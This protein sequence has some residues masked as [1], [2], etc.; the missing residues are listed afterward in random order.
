MP[1]RSARPRVGAH[2]MTRTLVVLLI[3]ALMAPAVARARAGR[4]DRHFG[5]AGTQ[6]LNAKNSD[7]VGGAVLALSNGRVLA[8]GAAAGKFVVL[9]LHSQSGRLDN[10]FGDHGQFVPDLPGSSLDG[11]RA[12]AT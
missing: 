6:T 9:R 11:V 3:A 10:N 7:A 5:T 2:R 12:L 8:G 4:P 1:H